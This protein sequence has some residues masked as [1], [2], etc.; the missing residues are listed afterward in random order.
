[1]GDSGALGHG[2]YYIHVEGTYYS[3][4]VQQTTNTGFGSGL[5]LFIWLVLVGIG[6]GVTVFG[7][8]SLRQTPPWVAGPTALLSGS[9]IVTATFLTA[10][11]DENIDG[12]LLPWSIAV[13]ILAYGGFVLYRRWHD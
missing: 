7:L 12:D 9:V 4:S 13:S 11:S 10:P 1:M 5:A 3:L 2:T 8:I 6:S